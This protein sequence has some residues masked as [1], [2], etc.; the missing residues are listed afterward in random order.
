[1]KKKHVPDSNSFKLYSILIKSENDIE[2]K[3]CAN[4]TNVQLDLIV[5]YI[6]ATYLMVMK[7]MENILFLQFNHVNSSLLGSISSNT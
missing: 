6:L 2:T 3:C 1:M 4:G 5:Y 7:K